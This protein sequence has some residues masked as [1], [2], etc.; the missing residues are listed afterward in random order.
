MGSMSTTSMSS[1]VPRR[2]RRRARSLGPAV[3][4]ALVALLVVA[5]LALF[6]RPLGA[7]E[8]EECRD[9]DSVARRAERAVQ[10]LDDSLERLDDRIAE[11]KA[12]AREV[13]RDD[14]AEHTRLEHDLMQAMSQVAMLQGALERDGWRLEDRGEARR[15]LTR[16]MRDLAGVERQLG[17]VT[18]QGLQ[19]MQGMQ[20]MQRVPMV[21]RAERPAGWLGISYAASR[22]TKSN[23]R[24]LHYDYPVVVAVE[25]GSPAQAAGIAAGDTLVAFNDQALRGHEISMA[26]LLRPGADVV[27]RVRRGGEVKDLV[28][29]VAPRPRAFNDPD[30][31]VQVEPMTPMPAEGGPYLLPTPPLPPPAPAMPGAGALTAAYAGAEVTRLNADLREVLGVKGGVLV[32]S[33]GPGTPAERGGLRGGDVIVSAD[34]RAV[35]SPIAL[36][37]ALEAGAGDRSVRLEVVRKGA[38]RTVDLRW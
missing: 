23:D 14:H 7:Q 1:T 5:P 36:Q 20:G 26:R 10:S 8:R 9:C 12:R 21:T 19:G 25:P 28:V 27:V 6:A 24:V 16:A 37:R 2:R 33:V 32:I 31:R 35:N 11:L 22:I 29:R 15:A 17:R 38:K 30:V 18:S 34:R 13:G 3:R 4:T